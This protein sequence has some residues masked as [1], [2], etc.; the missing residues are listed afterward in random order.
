MSQPHHRS[1][2]IWHTLSMDYTVLPTTHAFIYEW[3][4]SYLSLLSQPKMVLI[5]IDVGKMERSVGLG[6][7][8]VRVNFLPK[9]VRPTW[10]LSQLL[11]VQT[12][13]PHWATKTQGLWASNSRLLEPKSTTLTT[14][15]A[16][17]P[18]AYRSKH[19]KVIARTG[20]IDTLD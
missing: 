17:H 16:S 9:I 6:T 14:E 10:R 5:Y 13:M 18:K 2:Q 7:T 19:L 11:A 20:H 12:V 1:A 8:K 3:D 4:E 15:P